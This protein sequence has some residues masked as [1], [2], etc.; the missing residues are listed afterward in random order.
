MRLEHPELT[1]D[2]PGLLLLAPLRGWR[3]ALGTLVVEGPRTG[4]LER[5]SA[6]VAHPRADAGSSR[7]RSRTSSCS[8]RSCG[9]AACSRTPSTRSRSRRR[10]R[11][12]AARR[13]DERRVRGADGRPRARICSIG[14]STRS[15]ATRLAAW[16]TAPANPRSAAAGADGAR[17]RRFED[18]RLG[19]T[20]LVTVT[21]LINAGR[22]A[23]RARAR[24]ARHHA[25][26]R[27]SKR[28]SA[29]LRERLGAIGEARVARPVRRRHRARDEQPAAG[30]PRASRAADRDLDGGA[31]GPPRAAPHLPR[32]R[33]RGE[34]RPQ[35]A[36]L[37]RLAA[38]VAPA[39]A[40]RPRPRRARSRAARRR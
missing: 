12:R 18:P 31:A 22:R 2:G 15:S 7:R 1:G 39:A 32:G 19:G 33:S 13:A 35:P 26:R 38:D 5:G 10:H 29:A 37:H 8:R 30:R 11:Q 25:R 27:G 17:T 36:G 16:A 23:D 9:S 4:D 21:P 28:N 14:R 20:F 3:R 34:D 6:D 24:R 40:H